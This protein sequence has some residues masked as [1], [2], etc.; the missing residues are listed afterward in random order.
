MRQI[1][2]FFMVFV[3]LNREVFMWK[4]SLLTSFSDADKLPVITYAVF[5]Y[6]CHITLR[7]LRFVCL[8]D[9]SLRIP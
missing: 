3:R 2:Y 6:L 5:P 8:R 7:T 4:V 9:I 1:R